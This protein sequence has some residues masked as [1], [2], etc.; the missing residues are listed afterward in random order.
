MSQQDIESF[1]RGM[2]AYNEGDLDGLLESFDEEVEFFPLRSAIEGPY[3]GHEGVRK[4]WADT[5]ESWETFRVEAENV[6][7]LDDGRIVA[8]GVIYAKGKGGGVPLDI[9]T[10]WLTE[11]RD[12]RATKVKFFF[13]RDEAF[14]AVGLQR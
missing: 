8:S 12:G 3:H 5:A 7:N 9:P 13:D 14:K 6:H 1:W 11:M 10:S 2:K 4:W